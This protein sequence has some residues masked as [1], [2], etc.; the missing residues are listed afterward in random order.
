MSWICPGSSADQAAS[1][2][3]V[4][5]RIQ[6]RLVE[7]LGTRDER[8]NGSTGS[9][10]G[11]SKGNITPTS[12]TSPTK[13]IKASETWRHIWYICPPLEKYKKYRQK[14]LRGG[15][16]LE[17]T[18]AHWSP[19][20]WKHVNLVTQSPA[21]YSSRH[22]AHSPCESWAKTAKTASKRRYQRSK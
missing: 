6:A 13:K 3:L 15:I 10:N 1:G 16:F 20:A 12:P 11:S 7:G 22:R 2:A 14:S 19:V 9:D 21:E 8:N 17:P 18:G 5:P 4:E